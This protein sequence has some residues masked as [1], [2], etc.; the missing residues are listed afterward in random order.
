MIPLK[1]VDVQD[2]AV[3]TK[4]R[5]AFVDSLIFRRSKAVFQCHADP[6]L[7]LRLEHDSGVWDIPSL[8]I[9]SLPIACIVR[10][11]GK[12]WLRWDDILFLALEMKSQAGIDYFARRISAHFK[13]DFKIKPLSA[14][15]R[16]QR[17]MWRFYFMDENPPSLT[18][19]ESV[20]AGFCRVRTDSGR[21]VGFRSELFVGGIG[22]LCLG[23]SLRSQVCCLRRLIKSQPQKDSLN[24]QREKLECT[25][26]YEQEGISNYGVWRVLTRRLLVNWLPRVGTRAYFSA[27]AFSAGRLGC[28]PNLRYTLT[29]C[30]R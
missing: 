18:I 9:G 13:N 3:G 20:G 27:I 25:N 8:D 5:P 26:N 15:R 21:C 24:N 28:S 1:S 7:G 12:V 10:R 14:V 22:S 17:N 2:K 29:R 11:F 19:H 30:C 6:D 4:E 16:G 23:E